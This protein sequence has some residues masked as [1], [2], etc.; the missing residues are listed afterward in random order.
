M[1]DTAK[2]A[3][4]ARQAA[5]KAGGKLQLFYTMGQYDIVGIAEAPDDEALLRLNLSLASL[6]NVRTTTMK[7]WTEE[8]A[9]KVI[10]QI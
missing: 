3:E 8:E 5:E 4:A 1:K 9:A 2:R 10:A 6:G 7:A